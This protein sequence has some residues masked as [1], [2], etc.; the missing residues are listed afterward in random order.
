MCTPTQ[1]VWQPAGCKTIEDQF[2]ELAV[3]LNRLAFEQQFH[4]G[5][6]P[7]MQRAPNTPA[8]DGTHPLSPIVLQGTPL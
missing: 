1:G 3:N 8:R 2:F 6:R 5:A 7:D 4:Y